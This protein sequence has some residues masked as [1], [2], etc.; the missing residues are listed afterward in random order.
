MDNIDKIQYPRTSFRI[1]KKIRAEIDNL[2]EN[3]R[4]KA[5]KDFIWGQ[6]I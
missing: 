4:K 1:R 5:G 3:L 6:V 2:L